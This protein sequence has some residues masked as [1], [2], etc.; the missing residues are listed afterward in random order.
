MLFLSTIWVVVYLTLHSLDVLFEFV[1]HVFDL[2]EVLTDFPERVE[3]RDLVDFASEELLSV[4][5][6]L[7]LL[8]GGVLII[9]D[10]A[11]VVKC[12]M[13]G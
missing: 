13:H 7:S 3:V 12:V 1:V 4:V 11:T 9:G 5:L 2:R 6:D 10:S 8:I